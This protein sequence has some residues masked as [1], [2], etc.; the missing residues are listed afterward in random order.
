MPISYVNKLT[1]SETLRGYVAVYQNELIWKEVFKGIIG[2]LSVQIIRFG[3]LKLV[4]THFK[5]VKRRDV[6]AFVKEVKFNAGGFV[7]ILVK[8]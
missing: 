5:H 6:E 1:L 2:V 7:P 4:L 3:M 8:S